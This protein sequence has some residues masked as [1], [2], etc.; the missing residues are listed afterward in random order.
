MSTMSI[1][2]AQS[3]K[4]RLTRVGNRIGVGMYRTLDGRLSGGSHVLMLTTP[5]R[6]TGVPRSTCMRFIDTADGYVVWGTGSGSPRDPE[7][8]RNLRKAETAEVQIRDRHL[9]VHPR[10]LVGQEREAVWRNVVLA[11]VPAVARLERKAGRTIPVALLQPLEGRPGGPV[12]LVRPE[13]RTPGSPTPGMVREQAVVTGE[14]WAGFVTT[15]AGMTSGW[16]HH[17]DHETTIYVLSGGMRIEFGAGGAERVEA[18]PG[19]FLYVPPH[20]IH[21]EGNPTEETG[22]AVVVRAGTGEVVTNVEGP[23]PG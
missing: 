18:G 5:G 7:W 20:A 6:K 11:Q 23:A 17:G 13:E 2:K 4:H 1:M 10:E 19:D 9:K 16:H 3:L 12:R 15:D 22:T 8:F 14:M 21:R